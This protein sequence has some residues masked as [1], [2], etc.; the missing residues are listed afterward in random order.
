MKDEDFWEPA[1]AIL[2]SALDRAVGCTQPRV[3]GTQYL[4]LR[5][6]LETWVRSAHYQEPSMA[7]RRQGYLT[8]KRNASL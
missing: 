2:G 7:L 1:D 8:I 5:T 3:G 4:M 6:Q